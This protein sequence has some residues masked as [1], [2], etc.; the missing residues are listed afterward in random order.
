MGSAVLRA[1]HVRDDPPPWIL[2]DTESVS[3]LT[4]KQE[5]DLIISM[6]EWPPDVHA[7]FRLAHAVRARVAEDVAVLGIDQGRKDYVLLGAGLDSFA[8]RH[9]RANEM[10]VWEVDHPDTQGWKREALRRNKQGEPSNL[11]FVPVDLSQA[12]LEDVDL[13]ALATW[14]W[15]GVTMYLEKPA[16]AE[17]LR[18]ICAKS[19]GT[20]LVVNF[21]LARKDRDVLGNAVHSS[22]ERVLKSTG[23]PIVATYAKEEVREILAESGFSTVQVLDG[24]ALTD[25]YLPGRSDLRLPS[26][27]LIAIACV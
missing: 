19:P 4:K 1:Q 23:E 15:M 13:P 7:G 16:T 26:S 12:G 2:E 27:T 5:R 3:L 11:H 22:A 6:A 20:V 21:L 14:N 10:T 17:V 18:C 25:R 24:A 9:P 8:W